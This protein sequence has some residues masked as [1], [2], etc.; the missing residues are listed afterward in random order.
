MHPQQPIQP[1]AGV[2]LGHGFGHPAFP[3]SRAA[4]EQERFANRAG[5]DGVTSN[6]ISGCAVLTRWSGWPFRGDAD[7]RVDW[8]GIGGFPALPACVQA[9]WLSVDDMAYV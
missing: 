5:R 8:S 3:P 7:L 4:C 6:L 1:G 2:R 9:S